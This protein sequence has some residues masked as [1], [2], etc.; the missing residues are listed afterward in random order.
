MSADVDKFQIIDYA[1]QFFREHHSHAVAFQCDPLVEPL[2]RALNPRL[3]KTAIQCFKWVLAYTGVDPETDP[4]VN[5]D[6]LV[7]TLYAAPAVRDEVMFQL[8]KQT[9]QN[10]NVTW[11]QRTWE[12]FLIVVTYFPSTKNSEPWIKAHIWRNIHHPAPAIATLAQFCY[13]RFSVRCSVGQALQKAPVGYI[14]SIPAQFQSGRQQFGSSIYEQI[15]NQRRSVRKLPIPYIVHH[16]AELMLRK[17]CEQT[18]GLFRLP[19]NLKNVDEMAALTNAGRDAI[20]PAPM[21]DIASLF[22]KW[23]RDLPDPV[24]NKSALPKLRSAHEDR[25]YV[26]F[27]SQLPRAHM[28]TLM[29]VIGFLQRLVKSEATTF[30]GAKNLAI[31]FGPN[32]VQTDETSETEIKLFAEIAIEFIT[33]LIEQWDTRYIYPLDPEFLVEG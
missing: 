4:I 18:E 2:L 5:A 21:N 10:L 11:L 14:R 23:F 27:A 15:W 1:R 32:L 7:M 16:M 22:K 25:T 8:I 28:L 20:T 6:R 26:E 19:G 9:Q 3:E 33:T 29:Y 31:V 17:G 12:L 24:V 13:I 30:M